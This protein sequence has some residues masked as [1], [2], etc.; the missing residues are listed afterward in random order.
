MYCPQ[1]LPAAGIAFDGNLRTDETVTRAPR[2]SAPA[3]YAPLGNPAI[4]TV[5]G[6]SLV[7]TLNVAA[8]KNAIGRIYAFSRPLTR[9]TS[10]VAPERSEIENGMLSSYRAADSK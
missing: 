4:A 9:T 2:S 8:S 3:R 1:A 5:T 10:R 7:Q 6:H